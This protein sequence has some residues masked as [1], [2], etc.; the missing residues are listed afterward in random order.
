MAKSINRLLAE[1]IEGNGTSAV[2]GGGSIIDSSQPYNINEPPI[3]LTEPSPTSMA[4]RG[5]ESA[6]LTWHVDDPSGGSITYGFAYKNNG[7]VRPD[8]LESDPTI[9]ISD[10]GI[11]TYLFMP[12]D[13]LSDAGEFTARLSATDG[14]SVIT[15][16]MEFNL[17]FSQ[18]IVFDAAQPGF[19]AADSDGGFSWSQGGLGSTSGG[20]LTDSLQD[21]KFYFE[22][23]LTDVNT[24]TMIGLMRTYKSGSFGYTTIG[25]AF[26]WQASGHIY[27]GTSSPSDNTTF[28]ALVDGDVLQIAYDNQNDQ[29]WF[30]KNNGTW[31]PADPSTGDS[32]H[33]IGGNSGTSFSLAFASG[34]SAGGSLPSAKINLTQDGFTYTVP[35]GFSGH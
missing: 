17:S 6:E 14:S 7:N 12:S 18:A 29:V 2:G 11:A 26:V 22:V 19:D 8:Q 9:T 31:S 20:S 35:T 23:E 21:G 4:L 1:F 16:L 15:R 32:G 30:N 13:S 3:V 24:N 10:S 5:G 28:G 34:S 27:R 25:G 33:A